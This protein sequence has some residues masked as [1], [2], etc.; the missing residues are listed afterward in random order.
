MTNTNSSCYSTLW[1]IVIE[2]INLR[3]KI[4]PKNTIEHNLIRKTMLLLVLIMV[5]LLLFVILGAVRPVPSLKATITYPNQIR[6]GEVNILW[7]LQGNA[8]LGSLD[9]GVV[10]ASTPTETPKP[11]ASIAKIITALAVVNKKPLSLNGQGPLITLNQ[12][13][14]DSYLYY[15]NI[16]GSAVPVTGDTQLSQMQALEAMLLPSA[17]NI[18]D[19]LAVWAFGSKEA[20]V[21]YANLMIKSW[22]LRSTVVADASGLSPL[23]VSTPS[24]LVKIGQRFL[25]NPVLKSVVSK[26]SAVLPNTGTIYNTNILLGTDG[27]TGIK[28]GHTDDAGAGLLFSADYQ[29]DP[30]HTTTIIGAVQTIPTVDESFAAT[31]VLLASAKKGFGRIVV[32][33]A[34]DTVGTYE[35]AWRSKSAIVARKDIVHYG[36]IYQDIKPIFAVDKTFKQVSKQGNT[37][38]MNVTISGKIYSTQLQSAQDIKGPS[39][40]WR[41]SNIF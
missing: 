39:Y 15:V 13:D 18:S 30:N 5:P 2:S 31:Q 17:N 10:L 24:D 8:A 23:T 7:P 29:I 34:G 20:Y 1:S 26:P 14:V 36:W 21:T 40:W 3:Y 28:T 6:S 37:G 16:G 19:S 25:R 33:K 35:S 4:E 11:T 32:V 12:N 38:T 22:G 41:L 9:E 27:I